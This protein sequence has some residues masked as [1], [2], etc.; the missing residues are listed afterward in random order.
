MSSP[1][2]PEF[3]FPILDRAIKYTRPRLNANRSISSMAKI[4]ASFQ[5]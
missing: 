1:I 5:K 3:L 2:K 4:E